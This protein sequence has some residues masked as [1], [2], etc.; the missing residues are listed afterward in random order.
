MMLRSMA[1]RFWSDRLIWTTSRYVRKRALIV[2]CLGFT[3]TGTPRKIPVISNLII[4]L[5]QRV[6]N[7]SVSHPIWLA[8]STYRSP[9]FA[10]S[11][12]SSYKQM[13]TVCGVW[14]SGMESIY[15]VSIRRLGYTLNLIAQIVPGV[16]CKRHTCLSANRQRL[17]INDMELS[18]SH[19]WRGHL[20]GSMIRPRSTPTMVV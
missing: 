15:T 5:V 12:R 10:T 11:T 3:R 9:G 20:V 6:F 17:W 19:C 16:S 7:K 1:S 2:L 8:G 13:D 4:H 18:D 14:P